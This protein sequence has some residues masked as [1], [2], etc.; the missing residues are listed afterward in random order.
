[1]PKIEILSS[2]K[3][4]LDKNNNKLDVVFTLWDS[5]NLNPH[6]G[7]AIIPNENISYLLLKLTVCEFL[8]QGK[9]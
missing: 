7:V 5:E 6:S 3:Q 9:V 4:S 2:E 1:M 8:L